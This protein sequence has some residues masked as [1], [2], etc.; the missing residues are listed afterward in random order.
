MTELLSCP[1]CSNNKISVI[2]NDAE[3][4]LGLTDKTDVYFKVICSITSGGCGAS[5]GWYNTRQEAADRWNTRILKVKDN[6]D[7]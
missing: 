3:Y 4:S 2:V 7:G 6:I 1:F 5:S